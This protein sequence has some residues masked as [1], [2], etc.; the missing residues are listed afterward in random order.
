MRSFA[1][2]LLLAISSNAVAQ[3]APYPVIMEE[4]P[5]HLENRRSENNDALLI[6][7][8]GQGHDYYVT[9]TPFDS[10]Q[11]VRVCFFEGSP[12]LR[13]KIVKIAARWSEIPNTSLT[14]DFG[15]VS[16][17]RLCSPSEFN[18]IRIGFRYKGYWSLVGRESFELAAQNEQSMNFARFNTA[19]PPDD[20]FERVVLHEFGH[21]LGF[22]HEHQN[23]LSACDKEYNWTVVEKYL[24]GDP[25]YWSDEQI[26]RNMKI[27]LGE[28]VSGP[29][30]VKSIMIYSFPEQ[31]YIRG[32]N[33]SCF[34]TEASEL[35]EG[36]KLAAQKLYPHDAGAAANTRK[37][38]LDQYLAKL[39][40]LPGIADDR[41]TLAMNRAAKIA[42][43]P[44]SLQQPWFANSG[45][46]VANQPWVAAGPQGWAYQPY[47]ITPFDSKAGGWAYTTGQQPTAGWQPN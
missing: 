21:A 35:S 39:N 25:N 43:A 26:A 46:I 31:F 34:A 40:G 14:L 7:S 33:S 10:K 11:P 16:A 2:V 22:Y 36:D 32:Q 29:F 44:Q 18:H 27:R 38:A 5:P 42:G 41:K 19:P 17:P 45:R 28:G 6:N 23:E 3:D 24:K 20:R 47:V 8:V 30:D 37:A 15:E 13:S 1:L 9:F 12:S 4:L